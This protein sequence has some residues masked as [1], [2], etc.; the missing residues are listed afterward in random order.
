[1]NSVKL[2]GVRVDKVN[3]T[4]AVVVVDDWLGP[5]GSV[6]AKKTIFTPNFE[7]L[8]DAGKDFGFREILNKSDLNIPDSARFGWLE[9][10]LSYASNPDKNQDEKSSVLDSSRFIGT[11]SNNIPQAVYPE[12]KGK[13]YT[14]FIPRAVYP[15]PVE[16]RGYLSFI[17]KF[18]H[19]FAFPFADHS[20]PN[21][22]GIDLVEA[23]CQ[24]ASQNGYSVA[25]IGGQSGAA[26]LAGAHMVSKYP[27]LKLVYSD[28]GGHISP[29]GKAEV[30]PALPPTDIVFVAY[31]HRKQEKWIERYK[32][33]LPVRVLM[34]VG[35]S[36]DYLSGR[37]PRAPVI[38]RYFGL[39]WL[40]RLILQPWRIARQLKIVGLVLKLI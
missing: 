32:S 11:P 15:E 40:F 23:L 36:F 12:I 10:Q 3:L 19:W 5:K 26:S 4:Q 6:K 34:G 24:L 39:E 28:P 29:D 37:V 18:L 13:G 38:F 21:T 2:L 7:F 1:M 20:F 25:F 17:Y 33:E 30:L 31:G 14:N 9:K 22:T 35:G 16:G 27:G 8:I